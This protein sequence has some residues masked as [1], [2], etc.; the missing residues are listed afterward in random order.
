[1]NNPDNLSAKNQKSLN[2]ALTNLFVCDIIRLIVNMRVQFNGL[3]V[4]HPKV[5]IKKFDVFKQSCG[6]V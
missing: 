2:K 6:I 4:G 5:P 3:E 1:M